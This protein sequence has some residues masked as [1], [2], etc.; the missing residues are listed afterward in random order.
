MQEH[1]PVNGWWVRGEPWAASTTHWRRYVNEWSE[2]W[3][4]LRTTALVTWWTIVPTQVELIMFT[5]VPVRRYPQLRWG[6]LIIKVIN[7]TCAPPCCDTLKH[8]LSH[9]G[10]RT[11]DRLRDKWGKKKRS[12]ILFSVLKVKKKEVLPGSSFSTRGERRFLSG[13][14]KYVMARSFF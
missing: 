5:C 1:Q 3:T 10:H 4:L 14:E 8:A 6:W 9:T 7:Y 2:K 13:E 11:T 12:L